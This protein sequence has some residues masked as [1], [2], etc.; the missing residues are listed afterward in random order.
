MHIARSF[1]YPFRPGALGA[2]LAGLPLL[3]FFPLTFVVVLGH[4]VRA[5]RQAAADPEAP[6]PAYSLD[7]RLFYDGALA[8]LVVAVLATPYVYL[9]SLVAGVFY[10]HGGFKVDPLLGRI[11]ADITA[12]LLVA[13]PWGTLVLVLLPPAAAAFAV[14][15]RARD[16]FD[17][18]AAVGFVRRR[19]VAWNL[20]TVAIVTAWLVA[21]ASVGILCLGF[22]PGAFYAILVSAHATASLAREEQGRAPASAG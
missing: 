17:A 21:L 4:A 11:E 8:S 3:L 20:A 18:A 14:S 16:L 6:P 5:T 13:I 15:G 19:F 22:L 9:A 2:W 1:T 12:A 10:E 7:G